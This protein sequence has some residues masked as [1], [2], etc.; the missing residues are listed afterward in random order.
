MNDDD[1]IDQSGEIDDDDETKPS[2][3]T[4]PEQQRGLSALCVKLLGQP[5]DKREQC[6]VWDRRPLRVSQMR[7]AALDAYCM[8]ML[9]DK[10]RVWADALDKNVYELAMQS[11]NPATSLPLFYDE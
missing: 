8:L 1:D 9:F 3:Q 4:K 6:S 5:V 7:Y 10:C 11:P 2:T